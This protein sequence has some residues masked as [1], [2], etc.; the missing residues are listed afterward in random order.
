MTDQYLPEA[1]Q[2]TEFVRSMFD[3]IAHR[4][5]LVNRLITFGLDRRWRQ[6]TV[7]LMD[8]DP[9]SIIVDLGCG[10]GD[11]IREA[12][13]A[14]L[15]SV[16]IDLSFQML[17][18]ARKVDGPF[19]QADASLLPIATASIDGVVSGFALRNF[20]EPRAVFTEIHRALIRG[21]RLSIL[22]VDRPQQRWIRFGHRVWFNHVV[23]RIGALF[24]VAAAYRYL[25]QSIAYLPSPEVLEAMLQ[26]VGFVQVERLQLH[27][28]LAQIV[29]ATKPVT[30]S[31]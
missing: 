14:G 15:Q 17:V 21:G 22:E 2:K 9:G 7:L 29:T 25:P 6:K 4:Y 16:G 3:S 12:S 10:T 13:R 19:V 8:L 30:S 1:E 5:D 28:G 11:L 18:S 26:S 23:P 20:S 24:S 31:C 27:G